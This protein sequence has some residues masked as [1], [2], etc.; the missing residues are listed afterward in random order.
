MSLLTK[1]TNTNRKERMY[2]IMETNNALRLYRFEGESYC[3][4]MD[5]LRMIHHEM[6]EADTSETCSVL[7][8]MRFRVCRNELMNPAKGAHRDNTCIPGRYAV[9]YPYGIGYRY[10]AGKQEDDASIFTDNLKEA[11][12]YVTFREASAVADFLDDRECI[13]LDLHEFMS[14]ADR[15]RREMLIPYDADEGSEKAERPNPVP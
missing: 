13:V 2:Q 6:D 3:K 7:S 5:V 14:E 4:M 15:F 11:K 9:G 10:Y 8:R 12:M 1:P